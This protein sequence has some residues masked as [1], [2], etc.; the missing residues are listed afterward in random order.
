MEK[1]EFQHIN[2]ELPESKGGTIHGDYAIISL[3]RPDKLNAITVQTLEEIVIA[4][5]SMELDSK[6]NCVMLRGTKNF[7]KKPSFSTG[8]DL[9]SPFKPGI[10]PNIPIHMTYAMYL[11]HKSFN[12]SENPKVERLLAIMMSQTSESSHPPPN[13]NPSIAAISGLGNCSIILKL[14]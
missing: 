12:I 2:I 3:N 7:T 13:A 11:F 14:L 5:N 10:K 1:Y 6:I 4:L 8:A 9:S